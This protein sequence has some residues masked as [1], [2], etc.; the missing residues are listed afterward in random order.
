MLC[1]PGQHVGETILILQSQQGTKVHIS[2]GEP[3]GGGCQLV[4]VRRYSDNQHIRCPL[5]SG[6]QAERETKKG[7]TRNDCYLSASRV[8]TP[9]AIHWPHYLWRRTRPEPSR[10]F[11][12]W[13]TL[14]ITSYSLSHLHTPCDVFYPQFTKTR[15]TYSAHPKTQTIGISPSCSKKFGCAGNSS[16]SGRYTSCL[17]RRRRNDPSPSGDAHSFQSFLLAPP[18]HLGNSLLSP[19]PHPRRNSDSSL[20]V[21]SP[22][23]WCI[24]D[25]LCAYNGK[26]YRIKNNRRYTIHCPSGT[27]VVILWH[28]S[29][30]ATINAE[31]ARLYS[32]GELN[33]VSNSDTS[34]YFILIYLQGDLWIYTLLM[35]C[36]VHQNSVFP[37]MKDCRSGF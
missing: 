29:A 32:N 37:I 31:E 2:L 36:C 11:R 14:L 9:S 7:T 8:A 12:C 25:T 22:V 1:Y 18:Y 28:L 24:L 34:L 23:E 10:R 16:R 13:N 26:P 30:A 33:G 19:L 27:S 6:H 15:A 20:F 4:A 35:N 17:L 3:K 5:R 21:S